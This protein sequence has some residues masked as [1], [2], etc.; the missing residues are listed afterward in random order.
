[1]KVGLTQVLAGGTTD[2]WIGPNRKY[3]KDSVGIPA[4]YN[5]NAHA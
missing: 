2:Y 5:H 4:I 3:S 1:M